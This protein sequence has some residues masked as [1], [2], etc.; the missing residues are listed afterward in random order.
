MEILLLAVGDLV[1]EIGSKWRERGGTCT[2][3]DVF[4]VSSVDSEFPHGGRDPM[5][6]LSTALHP[7]EVADETRFL[8]PSP[9]QRL[10]NAVLK[11]SLGNR[12]QSLAAAATPGLDIK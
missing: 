1:C 4:L 11:L 5:K 6:V 12:N 2:I 8:A 7:R 3:D 10:H 9:I